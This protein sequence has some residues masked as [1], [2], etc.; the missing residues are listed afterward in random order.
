MATRIEPNVQFIR[1]IQAAGGESL[2]KCYQCATCSVIC[3]LSPEEAPFP[4]KEMIWAQWGLKDKLVNDIDIWLCHNCGECSDNCPR[5]AKPG[6]LL[7]ALRNMAYKSLAKPAVIGE[8]MSSPKYLPILAGIP[9]VLFLIIWYLTTGLSIPGGEIIFAKV[10]PT[11]QTID[12]LFILVVLFVIFTFGT[13]IG[14]MTSSFREAG[15]TPKEDAPGIFQSLIAVI[16]DEIINHRKFKDCESNQD[17]YPG[18]LL[19]FYGFI[20]L[21]VVTGTIAVF[22]WTNKLFGFGMTT[23]LA[24]WNPVK[25]LANAGGIALIVGLVFLTRNRLNADPKKSTNSYYDW[26]LIGVIWV[27]A[28]TGFLA[29]IFRLADAAALAYMVYYLHLVSIFMLFAYLPWSKLAHLVYRTVALAYARQI[30]RKG[31]NE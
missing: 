17:R 1:E 10:Y 19:V 18:H 30:G 26:Y 13:A 21:A 29:Q 25:L 27:V 16:K 9:A 15:L 31:L 5:G 11:L 14:K 28:V 8:W 4:R 6:D 3:P 2:K 12:P 22:Y 23:P 24:L 20:A 7:A